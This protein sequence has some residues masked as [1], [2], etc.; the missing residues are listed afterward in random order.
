MNL[1]DTNLS[2]NPSANAVLHMLATD[3]QFCENDDLLWDGSKERYCF[4]STTYAFYNGRER[5]FS[6][7]VRHRDD[8]LGRAF[9][10][11]VAEYRSSDQ[12]VIYRNTRSER[13]LYDPVSV[14]EIDW[15]SRR[16]CESVEEAVALIS[17]FVERYLVERTEEHKQK[18][19]TRAAIVRER[20]L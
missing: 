19:A 1:V 7:L 6:L 15:D 5:G 8:P 9:A 13:G 4:E 20:N 18:H 3:P 14:D 16:F 17:S 12:I 10:L 11:S 2:L